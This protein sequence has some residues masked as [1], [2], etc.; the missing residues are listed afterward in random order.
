[1]EQVSRTLGARRLR[2]PDHPRPELVQRA[3][4][5]G[6]D[7]ETIKE[8]NLKKILKNLYEPL[9]PLKIEIYVKE[10]KA[11]EALYKRR[12]ISII[13]SE[14]E[15]HM[16]EV[17]RG[18]NFIQNDRDFSIDTRTIKRLTK[19]LSE[20]IWKNWQND[21]EKTSNYSHFSID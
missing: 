6:V 20:G 3:E 7:V 1:M 11:W 15:I 14:E 17:D 10:P 21:I 19:D 12:I 8:K 16:F 18:L 13:D 5:A 2:H 9:K 4:A